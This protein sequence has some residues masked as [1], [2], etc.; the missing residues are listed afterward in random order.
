CT[1]R[2]RR[3]IERRMFVELAHGYPPRLWVTGLASATSCSCTSTIS[4]PSSPSCA[5][6]TRPCCA[7]RP[8]RPGRAARIR[9]RPRGQHRFPRRLDLSDRSAHA[10]AP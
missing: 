6:R 3:A 4:R 2:R 1:Q 10:H 5:A 8:T 7:S 9:R